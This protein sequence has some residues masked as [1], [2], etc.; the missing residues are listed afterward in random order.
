MP[1]PPFPFRP[2]RQIGTREA[3]ARGEL[4][5]GEGS[6]T[7][8]GVWQRVCFVPRSREIVQKV[9]GRMCVF[10]A[11]R[12]MKGKKRFRNCLC[13]DSRKIH[14][15]QFCTFPREILQAGVEVIFELRFG[16]CTKYLLRS[17]SPPRFYKKSLQNSPKG[18]KYWTALKKVFF[19]VTSVI[20]ARLISQSHSSLSQKFFSFKT[21]TVSG[22]LHGRVRDHWRGRRA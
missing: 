11:R 18:Q 14:I 12:T 6:L 17:L 22:L 13:P 7:F 20:F 10:S 2:F 9:P 16:L 4:T 19:A 5:V 1:P 15:W 8:A 3:W 21:W